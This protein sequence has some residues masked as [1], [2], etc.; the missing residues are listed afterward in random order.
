MMHELMPVADYLIRMRDGTIKQVNPFTGTEVWTVPGRGHR[1]LGD[2]AKPGAPLDPAKDGAYCA[3]CHGRVFETPPEKARLVRTAVGWETR[4][5]LT[6]DQLS[7]TDWAFR[8]VPNLFEI[9]SCEYWQKNY[10]YTPPPALQARKE[11]YIAT[12]PGRRHV[13]AIIDARMRLCG[14]DDATIRETPVQEKLKMADAFFGGGHE[15][16][17]AHQHFVAGATHDNQLASSGTMTPEEHYQYFRFTIEALRDIYLSNR[18]VRYVAVFQNWLKPA[19]ASFDHLHKQLVAIDER[20]VSNDM[21]IRLVRA[22]PNIYNEEAVNFA[23]HRNLVFAE[24]DH[25]IAFAGFGHRFPT[26]EIYSKSERSQPWNHSVDELR[27]VSD[28][29]HACH[30]AMGPGIPCNEEWHYKPPDADVAMPWR[31]QIKWRVSNPAGFEG[32][33]LIYVNT[34]DPDSLRDKVVPRL[35]QLKGEDRIAPMKIAF[36][37][38][39]VPNCLKYNPAIRLQH[40]REAEFPPLSGDARGEG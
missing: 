21:E 12:E 26:L 3:F 15:L 39:C 35:F 17:I 38:D 22:N 33:T 37:C 29:V 18:Y 14:A 30:A 5:G 7:D 32:G 40:T 4:K 2:D 28:L 25:A 34:I 27:G 36:E 10:R 13:L 6:A 23:A 19:G 16:I 1:P 31:V 9:V 8:R 24:N 20:G 11:S